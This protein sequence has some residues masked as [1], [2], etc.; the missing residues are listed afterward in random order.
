MLHGDSSFL[1]PRIL[2]KFLYG[3]LWYITHYL[4]S[5]KKCRHID[6]TAIHRCLFTMQGGPKKWGHY[7]WRLRS[8]HA[9]IFKMPKQ[10]SVI[11][12]LLQRRYILNTS[13]DSI[14]IK[15]I[16]HVW[17]FWRC[18]HAKICKRSGLTFFGPPCIQGGSKNKPA[19]TAWL[20][21]SSKHLNQFRHQFCLDLNMYRPLW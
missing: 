19:V 8:L 3:W 21:A 7:V 15:L 16:I 18:G 10:I 9:H 17:A 1:T 14:F 12:G 2:M 6:V 4:S 5:A 13:V 20:L 11:F